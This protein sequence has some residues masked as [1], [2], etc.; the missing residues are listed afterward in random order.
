M[1]FVCGFG[2]HGY[3]RTLPVN[4]RGLGLLCV[5]SYSAGMAFGFT[6][7]GNHEDSYGGD[8]ADFEFGGDTL[9]SFSSTELQYSTLRYVCVEGLKS[10]VLITHIGRAII[11]SR[12][13]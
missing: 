5:G 3:Q 9:D 10:L 2:W 13:R 6:H 8:G 11:A 12:S 4:A 7:V 1:Q